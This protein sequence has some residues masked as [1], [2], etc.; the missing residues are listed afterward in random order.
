V[1][2]SA[3]HNDRFPDKIPVADIKS[4]AKE[5]VNREARGV[6]PITLIKTARAQILSAKEH[7]ANGDLR[8][9]LASFIKA[10]TLAK[11][12]MDS[13]EYQEIRSR[14]GI[15]RNELNDFLEVSLPTIQ[16]DGHQSQNPL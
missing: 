2:F 6:S 11:M 7:E 10:A 5:A 14:G 4:K 12:A 1:I 9:A 3:S 16:A 8:S 15:L 13:N